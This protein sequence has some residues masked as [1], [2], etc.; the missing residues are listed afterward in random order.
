MSDVARKILSLCTELGHD[1]NPY[2]PIGRMQ[3]PKWKDG[4]AFHILKYFFKKERMKGKGD[5]KEGMGREG[6]VQK[7][8]HSKA[9][10]CGMMHRA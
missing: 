1:K 9:E 8:D 5:G 10:S 4:M 2:R 3:S 6:E 7:R